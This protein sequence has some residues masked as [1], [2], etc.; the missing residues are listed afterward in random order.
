MHCRPLSLLLAL[1]LVP[2]VRLS[3]TPSSFIVAIVR[4]DGVM[5]P[6]ATHDRGRWR[7]PWPGPAREAEV[8]VR[9]EDCPLA[10]W[11]LRE[12]PTDW[13]LHVPNEP[14]RR[15]AA[16]GVTWVLS[17][18]QQQVAL[19]ARGARRGPMRAADGR[20][21]PTHGVAIAGSA[22]VAVPREVALDS[23]EAAALLDSLQPT[24]NREERLMLAGDYFAVY[25]PPV[26][27]DDRDRMPLQALSIHAGDGRGGEPVYF[28]EVERRYPR[29]RP[30]H[31]RWCDEVT[32][33]S[34]WVH[35][36]RGGTLELSS[37]SRNV[38][39]CLLD[40]VVRAVPHAVIESPAGPVWLVEEYRP[41][42]E[43]FA[44]YLAPDRDGAE[45]VARRFA[46]SCA[47]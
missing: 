3:A 16:D 13:S 1:L 27:G 20:R 47:R 24:F 19:H 22:T 2:G 46:G 43:A 41:E 17:Y 30:E 10:W 32:Y 35:R 38:T 33:M 21:A 12:P 26:A 23:A 18:C 42:A 6:V 37:I 7:M 14:P 34:G 45:L 5:L 8:P 40:S 9:L 28:V 4:D 11:G 44:L 25:S 31:L 29:K 36:G 39:S 15:I